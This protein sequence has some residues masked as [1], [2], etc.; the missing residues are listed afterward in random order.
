M[1]KIYTTLLISLVFAINTSVFAQFELLY[2]DKAGNVGDSII[3][4]FLSFEGYNITFVDNTTFKSADYATADIYAAYDAIFIGE[5]L[6]SGDVAN[7]ANAG[8]PIP[9]ILTEGWAVRNN[10]WGWLEDDA[11]QF[12]QLGGAD[13]ATADQTNRLVFAGDE[14]TWLGRKYEGID[15]IIW[16]NKTGLVGGMSGVKLDEVIYEAVAIASFPVDSL[17]GKPSVWAIPE[18]SSV[19]AGGVDYQL[20]G[21]VFMGLISGGMDSISTDCLGLIF[22]SLKWVTGIYTDIKDITT[23]YNNSLRAWPNPATDRINLSFILDN[24]SDVKINIYDITGKIVKT[25]KA[26]NLISG[27]NT[28]YLNLSDLIPSNYICEVVTQKDVFR[29][30]FSKN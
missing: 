21:M 18:G 14:E 6:G 23:N 4:S 2:V 26:E 22:N 27:E 25:S 13:G 16:T 12:H 7:F 29:R 5:A 28:I 15:E 20:P 9:C 24:S 10:K 3:M 1:K 17:E 30:R 19:T 8:Y 11:T